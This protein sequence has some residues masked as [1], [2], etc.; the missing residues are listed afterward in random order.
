MTGLWRRLRA[1]RP[2]FVWFVLA[3]LVTLTACG[4]SRV[5]GSGNLVTEAREVGSFT[6]IDVRGGANVE[7]RVDP[8]LSQS[9]SVTYDDNVIDNIVTR[10]NGDTLI[11]DTE[12]SFSTS[13]G[14]RRFVT[15]TTDRIEVIEASG[16]AD[17]NGSGATESYRL[18]ASGGSDVDLV[19][20]Q[21]STV[22]IEASGGSDVSI[23]ASES[24]T[25]EASGAADV[26][27]FGNPT[28][29]NIEESGVADVK[30]R[31]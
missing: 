11:V 16:G 22:E 23:F 14:G 2:V 18:Q 19:D 3:G 27:I 13:G 26:Q 30:L 1:D 6:R 28:S 21:A 15:V 10:V 8:N 17:V 4:L 25:G 5:V 24:I 7:L 9:V 12:G 31:G 20:L 29:V